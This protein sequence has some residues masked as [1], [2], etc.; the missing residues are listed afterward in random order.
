M[1]QPRTSSRATRVRV[2]DSV[3]H[4]TIRLAVA[5]V[6]STYACRLWPAPL[7]EHP[8]GVR[9]PGDD[10]SLG[11]AGPRNDRQLFRLQVGIH[12]SDLTRRGNDRAGDTGHRRRAPKRRP[13]RGCADQASATRSR[14]ATG[15]SIGTCRSAPPTPYESAPQS[16]APHCD[17]WFPSRSLAEP[18]PEADEHLGR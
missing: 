15:R 9:S 5:S 3:V 12:R 11:S 16:R 13:I 10:R 17:G 18:G 8:A 14:A 2:A 1:F 4:C 6:A 7:I